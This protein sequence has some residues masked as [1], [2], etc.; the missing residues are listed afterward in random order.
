MTKH[1]GTARLKPALALNQE[2]ETHST[3]APTTLPCKRGK[4]PAI[5]ASRLLSHQSGENEETDVVPL[6]IPDSQKHL[7]LIIGLGTSSFTK[8]GKCKTN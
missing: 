1:K 5:A 3:P 2:E 8:Q 6:R 4:Y 7:D